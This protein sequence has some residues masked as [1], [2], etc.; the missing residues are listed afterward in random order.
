MATTSIS[1]RSHLRYLLRLID[2]DSTEKLD[3]P[4]Y[5]GEIANSELNISNTGMVHDIHRYSMFLFAN[6]P[7]ESEYVCININEEREEEVFLNP[8]SD[9]TNTLEGSEPY[10][11]Q[12][13][14]DKGEQRIFSRVFG[15]ARIK[16]CIQNENRTLILE[17]L[18]IVCACDT[19][20]YQVILSDMLDELIDTQDRECID[21]ML[22]PIM[23]EHEDISMVK[24]ASVE[25]SAK[26]LKSLVELGRATL[27]TFKR[28]LN[29]YI[30]HGHCRTTKKE[31][32]VSPS[33]VRRLGRNELS[34]LAQNSK[35]LYESQNKTAISRNG[36]Y[37]MTSRLQTEQIQKS[38]NNLENQALVSFAEEISRVFSKAISE[39]EAYIQNFM[40]ISGELK[41]INI[42]GSSLPTLIVIE[43]CLKKEIPVIEEAK[44][45]QKEAKGIRLQLL[46]AFPD[47]VEVQYALP[48]RTKVFQ[49]VQPYADI[50]AEMRKWNS[51]GQINILRDVLALHTWRVDKLYEYYVLYRILRCFKERGFFLNDSLEMPIKQYEYSLEKTDD[52]FRNEKQVANTYS[53]KR[54]NEYIVLYYQPVIYGDEHEENGI[55]LHRVTYGR[56]H[57]YWTPDFLIMHNR[58]KKTSR[59]I[60]DAKFRKK[61]YVHW[62][63]AHLKGSEDRIDQTNSAFLDC[64]LKYKVATCAADANVDAVWILYGRSNDNKTYVYQHSKWAKKYFRGTPDGIASLSPQANCVEEMMDVIGI[65]QYNAAAGSDYKLD[66]STLSCVD[67]E[68]AGSP[69]V[70]LSRK[71]YFSTKKTNERLGYSKMLI[72]DLLKVIYDKDLLFDPKYAQRY[73]GLPH[74]I[75]RRRPATGHEVRLYS[76]QMIRIGELEGYIYLNWLPNNVN[77]VNQFVSRFK[78]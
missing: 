76:S 35:E 16:F 18:N 48:K 64:M 20:D 59:I 70:G 68:S 38:F 23:L 10:C 45:I 77:R 49:E 50:H 1:D 13:V 47:I 30:L 27:Q 71:K 65:R 44:H 32:I 60:I 22:S 19:D 5:Q 14:F 34:W 52:V 11:Y 43:S 54:G 53:L 55:D 37:Y 7:I 42:D 78:R 63:N 56:R 40:Q 28:H 51:F 15:L 66:M 4:L 61:N 72:E 46:K 21:W 36:R 31:M 62:N 12:V 3:L 67:E 57:P 39:V 29:Y 25:N 17:T 69:R 58:D 2:I 8:I 9:M 26:N 6:S 75:M 73:L 41:R 33:S 74:A 24:S